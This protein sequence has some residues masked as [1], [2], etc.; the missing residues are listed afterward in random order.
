MPAMPSATNA[1]PVMTTRRGPA[2]R[3]QRCCTQAPTVQKIVQPVRAA[4]ATQVGWSRT[5]WK[6]SDT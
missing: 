1:N 4:P 3:I 6:V 2:V 5:S